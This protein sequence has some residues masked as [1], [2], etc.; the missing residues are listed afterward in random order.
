MRELL[1][2]AR[3]T[4]R[5]LRRTRRQQMLQVAAPEPANEAG[6]IEGTGS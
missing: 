6:P 4:A 5:G 3:G 1:T 2:V